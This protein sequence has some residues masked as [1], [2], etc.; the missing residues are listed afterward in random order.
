VTAKNKQT[1]S[2]G[3]KSLV[4]DVNQALQD[5]NKPTDKAQKDVYRAQKLLDDDEGEPL[6]LKICVPHQT[7]SSKD[8]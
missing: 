5:D 6:Q 1:L 2:E 8:F 4:A 7:P 3:I